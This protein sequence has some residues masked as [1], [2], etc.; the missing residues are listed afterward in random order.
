[1]VPGSQTSDECRIISRTAQG[2][3][4]RT[5][6]C[7]LC[8]WKTG[9]CVC[10]TRREAVCGRFVHRVCSCWSELL[11]VLDKTLVVWYM[12][13]CMYHTTYICICIHTTRSSNIIKQHIYDITSVIT[14]NLLTLCNVLTTIII[15][16]TKLIL[17]ANNDVKMHVPIKILHVTPIWVH[18]GAP[19][20]GCVEHPEGV[21]NYTHF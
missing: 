5:S 6:S 8:W 15:I 9:L 19:L 17:H 7:F 12:H 4:G 20:K 10:S 1:M 11:N 14:S 16:L 21:A 3:R 2:V 13:M 18:F